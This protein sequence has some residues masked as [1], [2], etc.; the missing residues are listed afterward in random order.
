MVKGRR[1]E[2]EPLIRLADMWASC[3]RAAILGA[4]DEITIHRAL[5][6]RR[7]WALYPL[8]RK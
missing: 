3:I 1:D 6:L 8:P 2:S 5:D 4:G 7:I